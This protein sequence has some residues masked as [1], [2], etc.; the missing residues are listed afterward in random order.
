MMNQMAWTVMILLVHVL[1]A[2]L[3]QKVLRAITDYLPCNAYMII[4]IVLFTLKI[5][6]FS[7]INIVK[8]EIYSFICSFQNLN[9]VNSLC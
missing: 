8:T 7:T 2:T 4:K 6:L 3:P 5:I 1:W 9:I